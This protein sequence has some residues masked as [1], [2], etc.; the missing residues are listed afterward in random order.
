MLVSILGLE[1]AIL[2]VSTALVDGATRLYWPAQG[3][4]A[5]V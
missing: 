5:T 2:V 3:N 4:M 1:M